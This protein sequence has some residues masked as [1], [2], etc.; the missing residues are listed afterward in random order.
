M[1]KDDEDMRKKKMEDDEKWK[2]N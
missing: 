1:M 2:K